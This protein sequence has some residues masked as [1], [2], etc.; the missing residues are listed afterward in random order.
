VTQLRAHAAKTLASVLRGQSL[1]TQFESAA[2]KVDTRDRPLFQ[3]LCLGTL[4]RFHSLELLALALLDKPF[5]NKDQDVF[6]LL[7][8]GLYQ[9]RYLRTPDHAAISETVEGSR[10]LKKPWASGLINGVLRNYLRQQDELTER[11]SKDPVFL[12]SHPRWLT[13]RVRAAWPEQWRDILSANNETPP[14]FI[15]VNATRSSVAQ[16]AQRLTAAD[17]GFSRNPMI[18]S[19]LQLNSSC[20]IRQLPGFS[21]GEFSVQDAAAQQAAS[22]LD[23]KPGQRVLDACCAPGGKTCHI[24]E[25]E[26]QLEQLIAV[27]LEPHRMARVEENLDRLGLAAK[28]KLVVGD[29]AQPNQWWDGKTFDRILLD[30]PCSA[31][32]VIRRHPDIKL[33]R[34]DSDL[35]KLATLQRQILRAMWSTLASG[36]RL[37]YATCSVLPE[38]NEQVIEE[39]LAEQT[40]AYHLPLSQARNVPA[41]TELLEGEDGSI[42]AASNTAEAMSEAGIGASLELSKAEWGKVEWGIERPYGRQL[43]PKENSHDG[44]YY[45]LLA[46]R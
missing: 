44:F 25:T 27:E 31:T 18:P 28:V 34:R 24:L 13:N 33:L 22:L 8:I 19:G 37:L 29:A 40:D 5:R 9:L 10:K 4:R 32:G 41:E 21:D 45:A 14:L 16:L 43:F 15:R 42:E 7:L 26:P 2:S 6:A 17:I 36:G 1:A 30:V 11:L 12:Y 35:V 38:E 23:L 46:K 20:D 39:F 3:E